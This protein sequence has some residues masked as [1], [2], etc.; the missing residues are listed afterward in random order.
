MVRLYT[1]TLAPPEGRVTSEALSLRTAEAAALPCS[2]V[3]HKRPPLWLRR[4]ALL[5]SAVFAWMVL[6]AVPAQCWAH[7]CAVKR[8]GVRVLSAREMGQMVGAQTLG[9]ASAYD[10]AAGSTYSWEGSVA[11]TN[12]GNGNKLT[13]VP[14]VGWT[15]RGGLPISFVLAHN[16]QSN[17][18]S[19]LGQK[20]THSYDLYLVSGGDSG[21]M[22][23]H[24][25]DD[26]AYTFALSGSVYTAPT[27]IYD[28]LV[29]NVDGTYTLTTK[30]QIK[31]HF[32]TSLYCDT[33]T[34]ENG[35]QVSIS[36]N[37]GNYVTSIADATGRTITLSYDTSNR[38]STVTDPLSRVWTLTYDT[39]NNLSGISLPLLAG[40][41]VGSNY[42]YTLGYNTAHDLTTF[43]T[44]GGR[45]WTATYNSA[46]NSL[47]T[48]TDGCGNQ[49]SYSYT[50]TYTTIT[51]AN[52]H[53]VTH[54]YA[55]GRL[56]SEVDNSS[57][58]VS[59]TYDTSNNKTAVQNELG[60][61]WSYTFDSRGN[62]LT[63]TDP[64]SNV[65]T[66]TYNS[67]N[68]VL[69]SSFARKCTTRFRPRCSTDFRPECASR[70][71]TSAAEFMGLAGAAPTSNRNGSP[72]FRTPTVQSVV[73]SNWLSSSSI[74]SSRS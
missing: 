74:A 14:L 20:W 39:N 10:S 8:M 65:T 26:L 54:N 70:T 28:T 31:Y 44:P 51:D 36:H 4:T 34:D 40:Q 9:H 29:H 67:H 43:T 22:S 47:A 45:G 33:I 63:S 62:T 16:S 13:Q 37:A 27:G 23:I 5:M 64:L 1:Q 58:S 60:K 32:N 72:P 12:T 66:F 2:P 21:N 15:Q 6:L 25:G 52:S 19:E 56:S 55:S 61:T 68:K 18:N 73:C 71:G 30:S 24:W 17:H 50:S 57:H 3:R 41:T 11:G 59:Y 46:D 69:M 48:E 35:N 38:I 42:H 49:T 53:V 7:P